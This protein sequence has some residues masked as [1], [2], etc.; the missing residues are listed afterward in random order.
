[1]KPLVDKVMM[2]LLVIMCHR[3]LLVYHTQPSGVEAIAQEFPFTGYFANAP[4]PLFL[5]RSFAEDWDI[6]EVCKICTVHF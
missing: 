6:A 4:Q 1:M 3:S 5:G 2:S